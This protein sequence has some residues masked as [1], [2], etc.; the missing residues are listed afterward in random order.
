MGV[1]GGTALHSGSPTQGLSACGQSLATVPSGVVCPTTCK[2]G[3]SLVS[4]L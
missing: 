2:V 3:W 4:L 1:A